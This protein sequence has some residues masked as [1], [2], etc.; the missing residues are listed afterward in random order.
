[1]PVQEARP[2]AGSPDSGSPDS[3]SPD[4]RSAGAGIIHTCCDAT[5]VAALSPSPALSM[6]RPAEQQQEALVSMAGEAKCCVS[7][8][9]L[10][11]TMVGYAAFHPP[12]EFE[13][14][15]DDKTGQLIEL[16]AVEVDPALRGHRLASRL[17]Q[18]SFAGG[19]FDHTVVFATLYSWHYDLKRSGLS[20]FA[21][22]QMLERLYRSAGMAAMRTTDP[23]IRSSAANGLMARVGL[24]CPEEV[25]AEFE[26]LRLRPV[27]LCG[28]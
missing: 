14:W 11:E 12:G 20:D 13:S 1:M 22:K 10:G 23:E 28:V 9:S 21:Y 25:V 8:A 17:L 4:A 2:N 16:G 24:N 26:R 15:G 5:T 18:A 27:S 3:G 19:R 7:V 6:F